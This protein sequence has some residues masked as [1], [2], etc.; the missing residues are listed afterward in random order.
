MRIYQEMN[1][2]AREYLDRRGLERSRPEDRRMREEIRGSLEGP[3]E[4]AEIAIW[5]ELSAGRDTELQSPLSGDPLPGRAVLHAPGARRDT[6]HHPD[7]SDENRAALAS[8][9]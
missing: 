8:R 1:R 2:E 3:A 9:R 5:R 6:S 4:A 7:A